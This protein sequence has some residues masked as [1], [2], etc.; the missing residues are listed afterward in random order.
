MSWMKQAVRQDRTLDLD[1]S[2]VARYIQLATM[3]RRRIETGVWAAGTQIPTIDQ[4]VLDCG[5]ARATV[6]QALGLLEDEGLL[7]RYR[8]KGTFVLD[9]Q[10][11]G[12]WCEVKSEWQGLLTARD[13]AVIK[14]IASTTVQVPPYIPH[15]IGTPADSYLHLRRQHWR[16]NRPFLL[17][18]VFLDAKKA[19]SLPK[20]AFTKLSAMRL[21]ESLPDVEITDARQ[22]LTIG[23]A[24]F[25][26]AAEMEIALNAPIAHVHRS[27]VDQHG[28]LLVI[29]NGIYRGDVIRLDVKLK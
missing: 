22:T 11:E 4:L 17:A 7:V 20:S 23:A 28:K 2:A 15:Q 8:A 14:L 9:R 19:K 24:D 18:D 3:F 16:N 27:V 12:L 5:V 26:T 10:R 6:R 13:D 25:E 29:A 21:A 1:R